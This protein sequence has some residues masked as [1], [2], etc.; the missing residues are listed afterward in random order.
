M[1]S[2]EIVC[3]NQKKC[4]RFNKIEFVINGEDKIESHRTNPIF[5]KDFE[6]LKG[7]IYHLGC[8]HLKYKGM[9]AFEAYDL[10]SKKCQKQNDTIFL[11]FKRKY[12]PDIKS[13]LEKLLEKS[14]DS[15]ILFTSDYQFSINKPKRIKNIS[16]SDFWDL[17]KSKKLL[18][19]TLYEITRN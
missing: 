10:L 7:C 6:K 2:I 3:I 19:N 4:S 13:I 12:I 14:P 11:E 17:H 1:P 5:A 18:F 9:G 8:P 16:H 15:K